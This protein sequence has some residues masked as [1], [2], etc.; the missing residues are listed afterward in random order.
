MRAMTLA[1]AP[2]RPGDLRSGSALAQSQEQQQAPRSSPRSAAGPGA[3]ARFL[4]RRCRS[5][6]RKCRWSRRPLDQGP[7]QVQQVA[8]QAVE[9][10]PSSE[11]WVLFVPDRT[12]GLHRGQRLDLG[13]RRSDERETEGGTVPVPLHTGVR[14]DL[15]RV[16]VGYRAVPLRRVGRS[17]VARRRMVRRSRAGHLRFVGH[18]RRRRG[19]TTAADTT[20]AWAL[21]RRWWPFQRW[22]PLRRRWAR[23]SPVAS[24]SEPGALRTT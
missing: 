12:V 17:P 8:P 7:E 4:R 16:P 5:S 11:G 19:G 20:A 3:A 21:Q 15:V 14:V 1:F 10:A 6:R 18:G 23:G 9:P 2:P 24:A 22:R 13:A